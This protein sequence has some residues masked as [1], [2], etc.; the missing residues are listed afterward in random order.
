MNTARQP[1]TCRVELD[2]GV[3]PWNADGRYP[4]RSYPSALNA[5]FLAE[6]AFN[7]TIKAQ[8]LIAIRVSGLR[9]NP[10]FQ[11]KLALA[12]PIRQGYW[13]K[14]TGEKALGV[15]TAMLIQAVPEYADFYTFSSATEK[16]TARMKLYYSID[17]RTQTMEDSAYPFEFSLR[18]TGAQREVRFWIEAVR[19]DGTTV[20]SEERVF[21]R[22]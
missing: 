9:A 7:A 3:I 6:G 10:G 4:L 19:E 1:V 20:R 18:L 22:P 16:D 12:M 11:R 14:D 5:G 2:P 15:L 8:G 13:R 21:S 17:G